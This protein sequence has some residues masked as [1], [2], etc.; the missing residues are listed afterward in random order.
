[1]PWAE[2]NPLSLEQGCDYLSESPRS[3]KI[4]CDVTHVGNF[5]SEVKLLQTEISSREL[6]FRLHVRQVRGASARPG[7]DE[8]G[9]DVGRRRG[10]WR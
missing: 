7:R 6:S 1:M 2:L 8:R 9:G 10:K 3:V 5:K 4:R